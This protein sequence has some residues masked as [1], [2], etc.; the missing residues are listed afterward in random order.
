[1]QRIEGW[2][3]FRAITKVKL[4]WAWFSLR[5]IELH[6]WLFGNSMYHLVGGSRST[7]NS[8][9]STK[10]SKII[11]IDLFNMGGKYVSQKG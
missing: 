3:G 1:M 8:V 11:D 9:F 7:V 4:Q 2:T 10:T 6:G 5:A